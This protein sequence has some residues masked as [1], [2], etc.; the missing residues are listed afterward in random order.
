ML[1]GRE[2][3]A[4]QESWIQVGL[5][6]EQDG[7]DIGEEL[8]SPLEALPKAPIVVVGRKVVRVLGKA[9]CVENAYESTGRRRNTIKLVEYKVKP[10]R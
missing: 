3:G 2:Q 1:R 5:A 9:S 8:Q 10:P 4:Y 7:V 6:V